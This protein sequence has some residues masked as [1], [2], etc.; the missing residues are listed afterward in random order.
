MKKAT[1]DTC[2]GAGKS[3]NP[4]DLVVWNES[5]F[6]ALNKTPSGILARDCNT[7]EGVRLSQNDKISIIRNI[8]IEK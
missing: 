5:L 4:G 7:G 1:F 3:I 6:V 2:P 8:Q